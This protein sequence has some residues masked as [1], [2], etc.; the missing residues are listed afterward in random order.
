MQN[1][2][3]LVEDSHFGAK[4]AINNAKAEVQKALDRAFDENLEQIKNIRDKAIG[5]PYVISYPPFCY[6]KELHYSERVINEDMMQRFETSV[7]Y[8]QHLTTGAIL[9]EDLNDSHGEEMHLFD[10][11][12]LYLIVADIHMDIQE[13]N[14]NPSITQLRVPFEELD[15]NKIFVIPIEDF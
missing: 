4:D 12:K 2:K 3:A 5:S 15:I 9:N 1:I 14:G 13:F 7:H 10:D 6:N 11:N 8:Y